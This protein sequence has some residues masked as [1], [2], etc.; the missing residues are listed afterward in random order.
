[1]CGMLLGIS[2][3][4]VYKMTVHKNKICDIRSNY[5]AY[6]NLFKIIIIIIITF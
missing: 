2:N 1:M 3:A 5:I 4:D 6:L